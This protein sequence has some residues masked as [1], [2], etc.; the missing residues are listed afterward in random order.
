M[1]PYEKYFDEKMA[2]LAEKAYSHY[3]KNDWDRLYLYLVPA[4]KGAHSNP[5]ITNNDDLSPSLLWSNTF[6]P[7]N[8]TKIQLEAYFRRTLSNAPIIPIDL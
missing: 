8:M 5:V 1:R 2:E 3:M 6:I 7:K 4:E